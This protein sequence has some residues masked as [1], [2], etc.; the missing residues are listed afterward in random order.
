MD[1]LKSRLESRGTETAESLRKRLEKASE[2][3]AQKNAFDVII[4]NDD[5]EKAAEEALQVV[6]DFLTS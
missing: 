1:D 2:E 3:L 6:Q 4:V 5:L